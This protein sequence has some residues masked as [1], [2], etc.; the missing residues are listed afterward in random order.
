MV[1]VIKFRKFKAKRD[2]D[3]NIRS[4][5][6]NR[7]DEFRTFQFTSTFTLF[8]RCMS[9]VLFHHL[10]YEYFWSTSIVDN[11]LIHF[12]SHTKHI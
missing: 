6:N 12:T 10:K 7:P 5:K 3:L 9:M 1:Q 4:H 2:E 8:D 11:V